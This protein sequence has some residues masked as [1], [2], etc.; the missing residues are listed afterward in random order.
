MHQLFHFLIIGVLVGLTACTEPP[1]ATQPQYEVVTDIHHTMELIIDP[2][3]DVI[4]S[5]AGSIITAAGE[6]DLAPTTAEEWAKVESAAAVLAESGNLLMMPGRSAG[7]DWN[8][9]ARGLI[10]SGKLAMVAA[11]QQDADA[12]FDAG[13]LIYQAC[14][15]CHNQY[16]VEQDTQ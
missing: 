15:A 12:L 4:W 1:Q 10:S 16:L 9:Y 3:T 6:Q 11:E 2:A 7:S 8:E 13:G 14:L 5:S